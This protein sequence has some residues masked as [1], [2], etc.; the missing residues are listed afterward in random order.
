MSHPASAVLFYQLKCLQVFMAKSRPLTSSLLYAR[1]CNAH[2]CSSALPL[3]RT[4]SPLDILHRSAFLTMA[5]PISRS[6]GNWLPLFIGLLLGQPL[7]DTTD[8]V[9]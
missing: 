8:T 2:D 3:S 7:V 9:L 1:A 6:A 4:R 5:I